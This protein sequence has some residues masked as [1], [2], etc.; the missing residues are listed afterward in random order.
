[1]SGVWFRALLIIIGSVFGSGGFWA[2]LQVKSTRGNA[3]TR[4]M[5]GFGYDKIT[6]LGLQYIRRGTI[7]T[8]ELK[9]F[10][11]LYFEPYA[12]LGGNGVA[13]RIMAQVDALPFGAHDENPAIFTNSPGRVTSDVQ[14]V[15]SAGSQTPTPQ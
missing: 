6:T 8:D 10:R 9:D 12:A 13:S 2:Y 15:S 14:L 1:M 4:L 5:M 7:T 11:T 3:T